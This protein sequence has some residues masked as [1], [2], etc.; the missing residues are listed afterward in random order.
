MEQTEKTMFLSPAEDESSREVFSLIK[1]LNTVPD[2]KRK[3]R[4][5]GK[6]LIISPNIG[7]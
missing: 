7:C 4:T 6:I 2:T 5:S 1:K 3:G